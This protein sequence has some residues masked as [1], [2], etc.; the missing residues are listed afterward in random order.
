MF[1]SIVAKGES[2]HLSLGFY[3]QIFN[4]LAGDFVICGKRVENNK[5]VLFSS[6]FIYNISPQ[7]LQIVVMKVLNQPMS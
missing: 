2:A 7:V 3:L 6:L 1:E 4:I 5:V